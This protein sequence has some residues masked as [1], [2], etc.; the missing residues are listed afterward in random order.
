VE[1]APVVGETCTHTVVEEISRVVVGTCTHTAVV[2]SA[3]AVVGTCTH[4]VV[5]EEKNTGKHLQ[6]LNLHCLQQEA[7]P[8]R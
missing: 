6:R 5:V 7:S 1:S 8:K 3:P 2:E 4:T